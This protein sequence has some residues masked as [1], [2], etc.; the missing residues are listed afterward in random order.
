MGLIFFNDAPKKLDLNTKPSVSVYND[1]PHKAT[2]DELEIEV[3][4]AP[5]LE[6]AAMDYRFGHKEAFNFLFKHYR[7]KFEHVARTYKDED[8]IQELS[9]VLLHVINKYEA[10]GS[11]C[12]NTLFWIAAR[13][14]IRAYRNRD[15]SL[16]RK[17]PNGL[18]SMN[19]QTYDTELTM[20]N[21]IPDENATDEMNNGEFE[22]ALA[23]YVFPKVDEVDRKII[24]Y[25]AKGYAPKDISK[26]INEN[27]TKIYTRIKRLRDNNEAGI[28]LRN[29][30]YHNSVA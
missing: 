25:I 8:I 7:K 29:L 27:T 11:S 17:A 1:I 24:T 5:S 3:E 21:I 16:K 15:N 18:V 9:T 23:Q 30:L 19:A 6:Q 14:H 22:A 26:Y 2:G 4:K 13:N 20:E 10:G 12:F 28:A